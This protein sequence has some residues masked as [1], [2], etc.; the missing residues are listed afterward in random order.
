VNSLDHVCL[1]NGFS[2]KDLRE[3]FGDHELPTA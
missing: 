3:R 1:N 2:K